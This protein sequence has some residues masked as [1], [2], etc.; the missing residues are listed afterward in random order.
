MSTGPHRPAWEGA[1]R[2]EAIPPR[3]LCSPRR[4]E[5]RGR[6]PGPASGQ[7]TRAPGRAT[8]AAA[9]GTTSGRGA[10]MR[11]IPPGCRP[12][13][14]ELQRLPAAAGLT[15]AGVA[16]DSVI[17]RHSADGPGDQTHRCGRNEGAPTKAP[18]DDPPS[19]VASAAGA[20]RHR[21]A[22]QHWGATATRRVAVRRKSSHNTT[23]ELNP[24][25]KRDH[26]HE[27]PDLLSTWV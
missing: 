24:G 21:Q 22:R 3:S 27:T 26:G 15:T 18:V 7:S 10:R 12:S 9:R 8:R 14:A 4:P 17:H 20:H 16:G 6:C 2:L 11:Y 23:R 1:R 5:L 19:D 25:R 13:G